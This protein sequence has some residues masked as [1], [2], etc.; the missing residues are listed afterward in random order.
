MNDYT[1]QAYIA[2]EE[3]LAAIKESSLVDEETYHLH[4][5]PQVEIDEMKRT[6]NDYE[7]EKRENLAR[8]KVLITKT[9]NK[10]KV[11]LEEISIKL[12]ELRVFKEKAEEERTITYSKI[13]E[14]KK[15]KRVYKQKQRKINKKS[16]VFRC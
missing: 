2:K 6:C 5:L 3:Y 15:L 12:E 10:V 7:I 11:N 16:R 14:M 1:K 9:K 4:Q 8:L 13:L